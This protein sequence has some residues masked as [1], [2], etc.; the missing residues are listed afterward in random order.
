MGRRIP[1]V[2]DGVLYA[3]E[4]S[5]TPEIAVGSAAWAAW[6]EDW[7]THS[8]SFQGP[9][10]TFTARKER[11]SGGDEEYWTAYRKRG[12]KLR[13]VYLGK[14]E[15]LTLEKLNGA[16]AVLARGDDDVT[17]G[18]ATEVSTEEAETMLTNEAT[19]VGPAAT[20]DLTWE[21]PY[22]SPRGDPLLLTKLST[23][24]PRPSLVS[25]PRLSERLREGLGCKLTLVSAP[26]GFGKTT[27]LSV[28]LAASSG[29]R[30]A[31]WLSLDAADNDPAYMVRPRSLSPGQVV[32]VT[33]GNRV[34]KIAPPEEE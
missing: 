1:H 34:K 13:K 28:G 10:G 31:V 25:R 2:A 8:F 27:L 32:V 5:G 7:A 19:T 21:R 15:K 17:V 23:L 4:S 26:A 33:K 6:L 30:F 11:R 16:A 29:D 12:G 18:S 22:H 24:L 20:D 14:V 3:Q 9:A